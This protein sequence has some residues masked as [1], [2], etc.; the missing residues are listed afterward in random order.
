M[1]KKVAMLL[2]AFALGTIAFAPTAFAKPKIAKPKI[3]FSVKST[4]APLNKP[5]TVTV[6]AVIQRGWHFDPRGGHQLSLP[7]KSRAVKY[8]ARTVRGKLAEDGSVTFTYT[9]TAT[10]KEKEKPKVRKLR[11]SVCNDKSCTAKPYVHSR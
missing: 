5:S 10:A 11:F 2:A 8:S 1:T 4:E 3:E 6:K 9:V 7:A